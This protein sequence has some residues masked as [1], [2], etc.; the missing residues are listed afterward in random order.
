MMHDEDR[1]RFDVV[2]ANGTVVD[3]ASAR[4]AVANVA[5]VGGK[6]AAI[7][8]DFVARA[9]RVIDCTGRY[10]VPGLIDCH[11]HIFAYVSSVGVSPE[12]AHLARGVVAASDAGSVGASTFAAFRRFIVEPSRMRLT[13]FLN[14]SV[15]G[16]IDFRFGELL[17]PQTLCPDDAVLAAKENPEIIKGLKIRLSEDVIGGPCIPLLK[18]AVAAGD[19]AELP[20]MI[21]MGETVEPLPAILDWLHPGDVVSHCYSGKRHNVLGDQ[22]VL[23]AVH[24]AQARGV[25]FDCAHGKS[26]FAFA[27]ARRALADGFLPDLVS[28]DT[29]LRNWQ[30]PVYDLVTTMSKL[31]ALGMNFEDLVART[32]LRPAQLLGLDA[33]GFG[34][35]TVGGP[36]NITVLDILTSDSELQDAVGEH[37]SGRRIEPSLVMRDG[38]QAKLVSWRGI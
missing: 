9:E 22:G 30:G 35:L 34:A 6:I 2:L 31:M 12:E 3:P 13:C 37:I 5:I 23:R 1:G 11:T 8:T 32:T 14:V 16:L 7:G 24:E 10:V 36:A 4:N 29:S 38:E 21:H 26:N 28:S 18:E 19:A 15:L 20:L 27:T 25:L 17:L 33:E